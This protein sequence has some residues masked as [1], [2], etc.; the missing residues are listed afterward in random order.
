MQ[1]QTQR[2][3]TARAYRMTEQRLE[4]CSTSQGHQG[5]PG[6][7]EAGGSRKEP[8]MG[9]QEGARP[10]PHLDFRLTAPRS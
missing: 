8:L 10:F 3:K 5:Q 2:E 1:R 7:P 9:P 6:M 4:R